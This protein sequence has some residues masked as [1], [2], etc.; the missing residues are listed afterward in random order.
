MADFK[1][2]NSL[3]DEFFSNSEVREKLELFNGEKVWS[4]IEKWWQLEF[5]YWVKSQKPEWEIAREK[6]LIIDKRTSDNRYYVFADMEIRKKGWTSGQVVCLELKV[7][8]YASQCIKGMVEDW[9]KYWKTTGQSTKN[10]R[11]LACV[12]IHQELVKIEIKN[13][14]NFYCKEAGIDEKF[15]ANQ[16][17]TS[18]I[19][20]TGLSFTLF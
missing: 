17:Y 19:G 1:A 5:D 8:K 4:G 13:Y 14:I 9:K 2:I 12:G 15:K 11:S 20:D 3:F 6:T 10:H 16:F 18:R 7:K